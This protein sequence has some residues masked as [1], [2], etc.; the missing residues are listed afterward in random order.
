MI[1]KN[2]D[3]RTGHPVWEALPAPRMPRRDLHRDIDTDAYRLD[4]LRRTLGML[5]HAGLFKPPA[6]D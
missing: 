2:R 6:L 3:L 5:E 4:V 1:T